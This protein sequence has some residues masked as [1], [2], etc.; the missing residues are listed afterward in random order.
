FDDHEADDP[1]PGQAGRPERE[2][3][4]FRHVVGEADVADHVITGS[5]WR[6]SSFGQNQAPM[7]IAHGTSPMVSA[8]GEKIEATNTTPIAHAAMNG[9]RLAWGTGS[10]RL[11]IAATTVVSSVSLSSTRSPVITGSSSGVSH[12]GVALSHTGM[13]S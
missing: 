2:G 13:C 6:T 4:Q 8:H 12:S 5:G 10:R 3:R 9:H 11:G 1:P 7:A